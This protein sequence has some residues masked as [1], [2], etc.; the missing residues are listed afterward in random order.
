M[1]NVRWR[2]VYDNGD[3][4]EQCTGKSVYPLINRTQLKCFDI[5]NGDKTIFRMH[6]KEGMQL[7]YR[8]ISRI[9]PTSTTQEALL[10]AQRNDS[11][12]IVNYILPNGVVEQATVWLDKMPILKEYEL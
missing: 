1:T 5:M 2:A 12:Q 9:T 11:E 6:M 4:L 10:V 3:T 7:V 8:S